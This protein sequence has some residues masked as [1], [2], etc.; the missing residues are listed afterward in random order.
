ME[1]VVMTNGKLEAENRSSAEEK[2][3]GKNN[4]ARAGFIEG[5]VALVINTSL[6]A[7]KIWASIIT[8]SL[9]L[10]ADAWHTLSDSLSAIVVISGAKFGS[11]KPDSEHPFGH[12]R[13]ELIASLFVSVI[14]GIIAFEFLRS[15]I[16]QLGNRERVE[17]GPIAI[18]ATTV[19]IVVKELM[20]QFAFYMAR[21]TGNLSVKANGWH[22]RSDAL[23]SIVVLIGIFFA[24]QFWWVDSVLGI[25]IA[26]MLFYVCFTIM[27]ESITKI[28]GEEPNKA[29]LAGITDEIK[30]IYNDDFNIHHFHLHNYIS[31]KELTF[32]IRLNEDVSIGKGHSI[33]TIIEEMIKEKFDMAATIHVEPLEE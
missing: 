33:A 19:S 23:S 25:I 10:A 5:T 31:Q 18:I 7:L 29:L 20:A 28:L 12:G 21:R 1:V 24:K 26:L 3:P 11:R 30:N 6:F 17:F 27:K 2:T 32:H 16:N 8:G 14:I 15:S 4:R 13:W 22:H 9:A